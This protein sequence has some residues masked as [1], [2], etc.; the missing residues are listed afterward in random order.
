MFIND[1][2]KLESSGY[3]SGVVAW[4]LGIL[5]DQLVAT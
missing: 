1:N 3:V 5:T 4:P 2:L